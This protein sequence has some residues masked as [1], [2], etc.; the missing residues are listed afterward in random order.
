MKVLK[1]EI[2]NSFQIEEL[3]HHKDGITLFRLIV[4]FLYAFAAPPMHEKTI[5]MVIIYAAVQAI[6]DAQEDGSDDD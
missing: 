3:I 6:I 4:C 5:K 1:S 2:V